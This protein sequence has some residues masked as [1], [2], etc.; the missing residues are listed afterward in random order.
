MKTPF[1]EHFDPFKHI[2]HSD[3][4]GKELPFEKLAHCSKIVISTKLNQHFVTIE[5]PETVRRVVDF[6]QTHRGGWTEPGEGVPVV[7]VRLNLFAGEK[8]LGSFGVGHKTFTAHPHQL[9]G[10]FIKCPSQA[11]RDKLVELIGLKEHFPD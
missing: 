2:H 9:D 11:D 10:F 8:A 6:I 4:P 1:F 5:D 7:P 3:E